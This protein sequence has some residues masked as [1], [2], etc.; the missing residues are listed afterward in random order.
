M[1]TDINVADGA[2]GGIGEDVV[3]QMTPARTPCNGGTW[4]I[5]KKRLGTLGHIWWQELQWV[6]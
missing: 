5:R 2:L 4:G 6:T 3:G 1:I